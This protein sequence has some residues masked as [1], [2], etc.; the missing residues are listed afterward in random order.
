MS[1]K[2]N[3]IIITIV[4]SIVLYSCSSGGNH[5]PT[6]ST[7]SYSKEE[8]NTNSYLIKNVED[9][10]NL[11]LKPKVT[12]L[13][14]LD[15][16]IYSLN[17]IYLSNDISLINKTN[18]LVLDYNNTSISANT[19]TIIVNI[20]DNVSISISKT[21]MLMLLK[22]LVYE[23]GLLTKKLEDINIA[24]NPIQGSEKGDNG[25]LSLISDLSHSNK[26]VYTDIECRF[27]NKDYTV[28][29]TNFTGELNNIK[30]VFFL[31]STNSIWLD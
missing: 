14:V 10:K 17:S 29:I 15:S 12:E 20:Y 11:S 9:T 21:N 24:V 7:A 30:L 6:D 1:I 4:F 8:N 2:Y 28:S 26:V 5:L 22:T 23:E 18:K 16:V 25:S 19:N 31:T 27:L 3:A 13:E